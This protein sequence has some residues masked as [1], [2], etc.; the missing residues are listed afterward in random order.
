[1]ALP[2]LPLTGRP[3]ADVAVFSVQRRSGERN[4]RPWIVRWSLNGRQRSRAFRTKAEAERYRSTLL[5]AQQSGEAFDELTREP[6]SWP[7]LADEAR[8][9]EWAGR[10]PAAPWPARAPRAAPSPVERLSRLTTP[11]YTPH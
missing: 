6:V 11:T 4:K 7:P 9:P 10:C 8:A 5:V 2:T 1:M 3:L